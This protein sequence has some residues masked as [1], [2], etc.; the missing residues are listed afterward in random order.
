MSRS[1]QALN[2][3]PYTFSLPMLSSKKIVLDHETI[4]K[5]VQELGKTITNDYQDK[6]LV[7]IGVL[8]GAFIF[9]ADLV[10][11]IDLPLVTDFIQVSSYGSGDSS[12]GKITL[13]ASPSHPV[14][15]HH[16]LLI[17]DIID[18]GLTMKWLAK[19]FSDHGAASVRI[20]SLIDKAERREHSI[21]IDYAGFSISEGFLVGYGLDYNEKYRNLPAIYHL[22]L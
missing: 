18:T 6:E 16:I 21:S 20:C 13:V 22:D 8:K 9:M 1:T 19:H 15:N 4:Q 12:S 7:A 10:Q 11:A 3:S 5:R 14:N 2:N 17:E